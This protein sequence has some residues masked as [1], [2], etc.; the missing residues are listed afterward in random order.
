TNE[1][2][3]EQLTIDDLEIAI[4]DARENADKIYRDIFAE[5]S[6]ATDLNR[7]VQ[8]TWKSEARV[9]MINQQQ[10]VIDD[11]EEKVNQAPEKASDEFMYQDKE[12]SQKELEV[13][14]QI[15]NE[16]PISLEADSLTY[17]VWNPLPYKRYRGSD[18]E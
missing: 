5:F 12:E 7:H 8:P 6:Y 14:K 4:R 15:L 9:A 18:E 17:R 11:L 1:L 16:I 3:V 13:A 2:S 10:L